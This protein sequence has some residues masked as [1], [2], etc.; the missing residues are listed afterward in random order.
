MMDHPEKVLHDAI[1]M[2][3]SR[4]AIAIEERKKTC[5]NVGMFVIMGSATRIVPD[6]KV[7]QLDRHRLMQR[8]DTAHP[9]AGGALAM[10]ERTDGDDGIVVFGVIF[11]DGGI[12]STT[13]Q[14]HR[15][16]RDRA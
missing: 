2:Y 7:L 13:L 12:L 15:A 5:R 8:I 14:V 4:V 11:P 1:D 3:H 6:M 16:D 9:T 10:F